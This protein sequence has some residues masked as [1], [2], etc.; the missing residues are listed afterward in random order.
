MLMSILESWSSR[1]CARETPRREVS[2]PH[3]RPARNSRGHCGVHYHRT[4]RSPR[5]RRR[6]PRA[7]PWAK[8]TTAPRVGERHRTAGVAAETIRHQPLEARG[9]GPIGADLPSERQT[10]ALRR[11]DAA[12][13]LYLPII[14]AFTPSPNNIWLR[15]LGE[16]LINSKNDV[17]KPCIHLMG[18]YYAY[19]PHDMTRLCPANLDLAVQTVANAEPQS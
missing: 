8:D 4:F 7:L 14:K 11:A 5:R 16:S 13:F 3:S 19:S 9:L 17:I 10:C 12:K 1:P 6:C 2:P 15:L 18:G